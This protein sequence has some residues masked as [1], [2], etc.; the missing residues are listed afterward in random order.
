MSTHEG[1]GR[2]IVVGVDGSPSSA[3]A[4]GWAADQA[5]RTGSVLEVITTW[6]F[7]TAYGWAAPIPDGYDPDAD[8]QRMLDDMLKPVRS[9]HPDLTI[10]P[11]VVQGSPAPVLIEASKGADLLVVGSRGHGEFTGM[12]LG[13]VSGHCVTNA[14]CPV[15]VMREAH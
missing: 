7:P 5:G 10:R 15:L 12:L 4:L 14:H 1:P 2:R 11:V 6:S 13:S 8:A 9:D 3:A